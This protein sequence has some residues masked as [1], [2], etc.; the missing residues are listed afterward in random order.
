MTFEL[1]GERAGTSLMQQIILTGMVDNELSV[2]LMQL[3]ST[4]VNTQP[5]RNV[6]VIAFG[7]VTMTN[8][9]PVRPTIRVEANGVL[10]VRRLPNRDT[11]DIMVQLPLRT[12]VT[13]NGITGR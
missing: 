6:A 11:G 10:N 1:V 3:Q 4:I 12:T 13:A 7:D 8:E 9:V 5:G 2:A